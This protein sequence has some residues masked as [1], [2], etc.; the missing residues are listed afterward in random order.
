MQI[1]GK[2]DDLVDKLDRASGTTHDTY[3]APPIEIV[4]YIVVIPRSEY[5]QSSR[6]IYELIN[7][8]ID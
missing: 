7:A 3:L 6:M 2:A 1:D 4:R 5:L 8:N